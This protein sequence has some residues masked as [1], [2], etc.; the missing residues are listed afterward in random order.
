MTVEVERSYQIEAPIEEVWEL[1]ADSA[2]RASALGV[3]D[4]F[5]QQG[6]VT[7]WYLKLPLPLLRR[8]VSV[9]TWDVDRDPPRYVRFVGESKI[10]DVV[11]EHALSMDGDITTITNR[12]RVDGK[13]P[14]VEGF[15]ERNIDREIERLRRH[16]IDQLSK[17]GSV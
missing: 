10:M 15:F 3:V 11:G 2:V 16:V 17:T 9:R 1:L 5:D 4:H 6:E 8:T 14:G 12:F 13:L 7:V